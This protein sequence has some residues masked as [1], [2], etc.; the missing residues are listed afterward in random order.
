MTKPR[1]SFDPSS[2][3][4]GASKA[5][6]DKNPHR[7]AS[8]IL[9]LL[10]TLEQGGRL[11]VNRIVK[12]CDVSRGTAQR[13]LSLLKD[14]R[15]LKETLQGAEKFWSLAAGGPK[16]K[17][18]DQ[19]VALELSLSSAPWLR[20]TPYHRVVS[21]HVAVCR[22]TIPPEDQDRLETFIRSFHLRTR[23]DA[24]YSHK[25]VVLGL[26]LDAIRD[27]H[28]CEI[29]Y[30]KADGQHDYRVR[31]LLLVLYQEQL[32]LLAE[33]IADGR[34]RTFALG[35]VSSV[36]PDTETVFA[37][38]DRRFTDPSEVFRHAFGIYTD[39]GEPEDVVVEVTGP[40]A[41]AIHRRR[42]H[43]SQEVSARPDGWHRVKW[44]VA[45]CPELESFLLSLLPDV[46]VVS[47]VALRERLEQRVAPLA[48]R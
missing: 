21:D 35:A 20:G 12:D 28:P 3:A 27:R 44:H 25:S 29:S 6:D 4:R 42:W 31:P 14:H 18:F 47:P 45:R 33:N 34:R 10:S 8:N 46:R 26:L 2:R 11:S 39:M 41:A 48:Q 22:G 16:T 24:T 19:T 23:G 36:K 1:K 37:I 15:P 30:V 38:P 5:A 32:Y 9:A 13:Y 7:S 17:S 40:A 43:P